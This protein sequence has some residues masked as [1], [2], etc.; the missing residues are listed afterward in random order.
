MDSITI[1]SWTGNP[2]TTGPLKAALTFKGTNQQWDLKKVVETYQNI[3][4]IW[5]DHYEHKRPKPGGIPNSGLRCCLTNY[6]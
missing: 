1:K 4:L 2:S 5:I 3:Y 6:I